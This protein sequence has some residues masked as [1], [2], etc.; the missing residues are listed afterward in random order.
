MRPHCHALS[1]HSV[2]DVENREDL[3]EWRI[4]LLRLPTGNE[5]LEILAWESRGKVKDFIERTIGGF[6]NFD[7]ERADGFACRLGKV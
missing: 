4:E 2:K 6:G 5:V 7:E 3:G 1:F